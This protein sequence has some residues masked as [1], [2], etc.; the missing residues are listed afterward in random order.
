MK[1]KYLEAHNRDEAVTTA[2]AA[3]YTDFRIFPT[4]YWGMGIEQRPL[5]AV[6]SP[7]AVVSCAVC[8]GGGDMYVC[9]Q[10]TVCRE[11]LDA[12]EITQ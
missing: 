3:G 11:C 4:P 9:Q 7:F 10:K 12:M 6:C 5:Y 1:F 2:C 8:K